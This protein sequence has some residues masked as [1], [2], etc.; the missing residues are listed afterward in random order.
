MRLVSFDG[1]FGRV[2]GSQVIPMGSDIL[3]YLANG[4]AHEE[5]PVP[6]AEV[7]LRAPVPKPGKI[8]ESASTIASTKPRP[9]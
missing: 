2:E 1:R 4:A 9:A 3:D 6:L 7:R 5:P 8:I